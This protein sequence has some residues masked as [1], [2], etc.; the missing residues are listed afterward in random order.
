MRL[1]A[2]HRDLLAT[3]SFDGHAAAQFDARLHAVHPDAPHVDAAHLEAL[4]RWLLGLDHAQSRQELQQRLARVRELRRMAA[5]PDWDTGFALRAR[6]A[7]LLS[8]MGAAHDGSDVAHANRDRVFGPPSLEEA[9]LVELAWPAFADE[10]EDYL[11]FCRF[12]REQHPRGAPP[13]TRTAWNHMRQHDGTVWQQL[14]R[15]G[16]LELH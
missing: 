3:L 11:D 16:A 12:R 1:P 2:A 14:R 10:L 6:L 4:A 8:F 7:G 5:D 15:D 13:L 9:L